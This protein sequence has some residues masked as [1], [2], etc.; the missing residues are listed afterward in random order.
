[1]L[2]AMTTPKRGIADAA[3]REFDEYCSIVEAHW[4]NQSPRPPAPNPLEVLFHLSGDDEWTAYQGIQFPPSSEY[5]SKRVL[6]LFRSFSKQM[7]ILQRVAAH[8]PIETVLQ[9]ILDEMDLITH[10]SK[11][12]K[13]TSESEERQANVR[14]LQLASMKYSDKGPCLPTQLQPEDKADFVQ[15]PL[16]IFL[17]DVALVTDMAKRSESSTT[18][19]RLVASLM[20]IHAS[21]GMEFDTVFIVGMEEGTIP[22]QKALSEGK[23]SVALEEEKRLCYVAMTRAKTELIMTWRHEVPIFTANGMSCTKA[24]QSRFLTV[25]EP[26]SWEASTKKSRSRIT[27]DASKN[28]TKLYGS[29]NTKQ[30]NPRT[31]FPTRN[32]GTFPAP[33]PMTVAQTERSPSRFSGTSSVY[34]K[35]R[36]SVLGSTSSSSRKS[37]VPNPPLARNELSYRPVQPRQ[38]PS[39][40]RSRTTPDTGKP[41]ERSTTRSPIQGNH[42]PQQPPPRSVGSGSS[43]SSPSSTRT[44]LD[45]NWFYPVGSK[46]QHAQFGEGIVLSCTDNSQMHVR[47]RFRN[48]VQQEFPVHGSEIIPIL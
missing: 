39:S 13:T 38:S 31:S 22:T 37:V 35:T 36:S 10:I 23:G 42:H 18:E 48:G 19:K 12:S 45:A 30:K 2:R 43:N 15:S 47:V 32:F 7:L 34:A 27:P 1:M 16:G 8:S 9:T 5:F 21:K 4:N 25:L 14:E 24:H 17:D 28:R 33:A 44:P 20:T 3:V 29:K 46:V 41:L 40:S 6:N 11:I 26:S